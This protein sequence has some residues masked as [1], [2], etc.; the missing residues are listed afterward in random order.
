MDVQ[1]EQRQEQPKE[2]T[3]RKPKM[4]FNISNRKRKEKNAAVRASPPITV[5]IVEDNMINQA[6]LSTWMKKHGIKF[7]VASDGKEAVEKWRGGGFHL[8]LVSLI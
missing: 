5:L 2:E 6:I 1:Q 8:I 4:N 7:S 3:K